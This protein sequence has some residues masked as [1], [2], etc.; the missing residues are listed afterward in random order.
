MGFRET[1]QS[2]HL[3]TGLFFGSF[4]PIHNGHVGIACY[5]LENKLC[6]EVWFVVSPCN[7]F[8]VDRFLLPEAERLQIV[9]AAIRNDSRMK[10]CDVEFTMPKPSYTVDTLR[11]L[12]DKYPDR[13]FVLL[14]GEDNVEAFPKW[15]DYH[16][17]VT[18]C[19]I[20]V[21][22][23]FD[24][25]FP[26]QLPRGMS[27]ISAPLFPLSATEIREMISRGEDIS[28]LVPS[29]AV[30]LVKQFYGKRDKK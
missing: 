18:N 14:M 25:S 1:K 22:P 29:E 4:N 12:F 2:A 30:P 20:F 16:W 28:S 17:I 11:F 3:V 21:Y 19:P 23:R 24:K 15:K 9:E 8:K 13:K 6:D 10:T 7:P 5:L 27:M 26:A